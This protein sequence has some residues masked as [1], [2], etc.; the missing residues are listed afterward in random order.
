LWTRF[1]GAPEDGNVKPHAIAVDD[2]G[3]Y[4]SGHIEDPELSQG[5]D[6][7]LVKYS[8]TGEFFMEENS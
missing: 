6:A 2:S 4:V 7:L 8:P 1:Y 3:V 5:I